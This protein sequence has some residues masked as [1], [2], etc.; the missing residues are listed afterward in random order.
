MNQRHALEEFV[1]EPIVLPVEEFEP[2][3]ERERREFV[4][5]GGD[6]AF[7]ILT[8]LRG[9]RRHDI[10]MQEIET[11]RLYERS[12]E[13]ERL[14]LRVVCAESPLTD[15]SAHDASQLRSRDAALIDF[16][17]G[18]H[19]RGDWAA[20]LRGIPALLRERQEFDRATFRKQY[21]PPEGLFD[22]IFRR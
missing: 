21:L 17:E 1:P 15:S 14:A 6:I 16:A 9:R 2:R 22:W 20:Q 12:N 3:S 19:I 8:F 5:T 18:R 7:F 10:T 11:T 4:G 13:A